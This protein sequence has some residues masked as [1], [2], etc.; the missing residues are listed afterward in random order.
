MKSQLLCISDSQ[1]RLMQ[2]SVE[3]DSLGIANPLNESHL[4]HLS[5]SVLYVEETVCI[6]LAMILS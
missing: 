3:S 6:A 2:T 1:S 4:V 5:P